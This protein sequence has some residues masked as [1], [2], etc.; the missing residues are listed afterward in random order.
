MY[1][2]WLTVIR[3]L[4]ASSW[5][6]GATSQF[7]TAPRCLQCPNI[8]WRNRPASGATPQT[9]Y[10]KSKDFIDLTNKNNDSD[11]GESTESELLDGTSTHK[12]LYPPGKSL[13]SYQV[14]IAELSFHVRTQVNQMRRLGSQ[15]TWS[16][17]Q[18]TQHDP[19][20]APP[21]QSKPSAMM[22]ITVR[23]NIWLF[24]LNGEA[25]QSDLRTDVRHSSSKNEYPTKYQ[26][27][28]RPLSDSN[29]FARKKAVG[30]P[31]SIPNHFPFS[32]SD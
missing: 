15:M 26:S 13:S 14:F 11:D 8:L 30:R 27:L 28:T 12:W 20:I 17:F 2:T 10:Y 25:S 32:A 19:P 18:Q 22:V 9:A 1:V 23:Y 31:R 29:A 5:Y 4:T 24:W 16:D 7:I 3:N 21:L 6:N